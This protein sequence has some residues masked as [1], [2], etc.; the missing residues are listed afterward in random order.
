MNIVPQ[1][2]SVESLEFL[3]GGPA[4]ARRA[5]LM[6][7]PLMLTPPWYTATSANPSTGYNSI[8]HQTAGQMSNRNTPSSTVLNMSVIG[9]TT[10][11]RGNAASNSMALFKNTLNKLGPKG[12]STQTSSTCSNSWQCS[13]LRSSSVLAS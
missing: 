1:L 5:S 3:S 13:S 10:G 8:F 7:F 11:K 4:A 6:S 12:S 9:G 2:P